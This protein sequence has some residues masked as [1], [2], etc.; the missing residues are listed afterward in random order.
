MERFIAV[1]TKRRGGKTRASTPS[2]LLVICGCKHDLTVLLHSAITNGAATADC[3]DELI[4]VARTSGD[5]A[6]RLRHT[7]GE[8][9]GTRRWRYCN[10]ASI[11]ISA[12]LVRR[13]RTLPRPI[14]TPGL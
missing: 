11:G 12:V 13:G 9:T 3:A 8:I 2:A 4:C 1:V 14:W 7:S 5:D 6:P 10:Y